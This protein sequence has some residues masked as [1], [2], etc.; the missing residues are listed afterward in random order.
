MEIFMKKDNI[1]FVIGVII[2]AIL[3]F[4]SGYVNGYSKGYF[5]SD[6]I[7][8]VNEILDRSGKIEAALIKRLVDCE[9][10]GNANPL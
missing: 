9:E 4:G 10:G 2:A 6:H 3:G 1:K 5:H 8:H 7:D